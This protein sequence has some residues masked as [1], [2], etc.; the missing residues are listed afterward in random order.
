MVNL[1]VGLRIILLKKEKLVSINSKPLSQ[2]AILQ[3][4]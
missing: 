3:K 2:L 1:I 4:T